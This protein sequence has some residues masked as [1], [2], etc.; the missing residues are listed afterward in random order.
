MG[1][2]NS[3]IV[4]GLSHHAIMHHCT[5]K[6]LILLQRSKIEYLLVQYIA[7]SRAKVVLT[8]LTQYHQIR[9]S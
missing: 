4:P 7:E 3:E 6:V 5:E 2:I 9:P 8:L 1:S